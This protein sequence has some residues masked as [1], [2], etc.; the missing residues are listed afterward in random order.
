MSYSARARPV[1][2]LG[3]HRSGTTLVAQMLQRMGVDMDAGDS[4]TCESIAMRDLNIK[5][6][7]RA[8]ATWFAPA[9]VRSLLNDSAASRGEVDWLRPQVARRGTSTSPWGWKDPRTTLTLPLWSAIFPEARIVAVVRNGVDV[10]ESLTHRERDIYRSLLWNRL[11]RI[12]HAVYP[13]HW[14]EYKPAPFDGLDDAFQLWAEYQAFWD[15]A[16]AAYSPSQCLS[17]RYEDVLS[18]PLEHLRGI[19]RFLQLTISD[20]ELQSIAGGVNGARR[21]AFRVDERLASF[22]ES[23]RLHPAMVRYGYHAP[24]ALDG[25]QLQ[26]PRCTAA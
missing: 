26:F 3:M 17:L 10:A 1:I 4:A 21:F 13:W 14:P 15:A 7:R 23:C 2:V 11:R 16:V 22:Y 6:L 5:L 20:G 19:A 9:P 12:A 18:R 25:T 24:S 8:N